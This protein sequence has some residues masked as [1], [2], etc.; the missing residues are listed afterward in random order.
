MGTAKDLFSVL[1][2]CLVILMRML[3]IHT[4]MTKVTYDQVRNVSVEYIGNIMVTH[5][6]KN[7]PAR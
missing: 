5:T 1:F 7:G 6:G 3:E 2:N 4:T